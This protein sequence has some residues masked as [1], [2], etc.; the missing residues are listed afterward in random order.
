M[1]TFI[2]QPHEILDYDVDFTAFLAITPADTLSTATSA[3]SGGT[4][5]LTDYLTIDTTVVATPIV[6]VWL[7]KGQTGNKYKVTVIATTV[8]GRVKEHEFYIKVK[9]L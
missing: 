8:G 9:D 1:D 5:S 7:S 2:K 4:A 3:I 6:K